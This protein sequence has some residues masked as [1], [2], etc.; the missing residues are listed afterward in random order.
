VDDLSK[1]TP[2]EFLLNVTG[3]VLLARALAI[4]TDLGVADIVADGPKSMAAL[5][6]ETGCDQDSLYRMLRM[7]AGHGVFAEDE[8][9]RFEL[10]PRAELLRADHPDSLREM[11]LLDWQDIQWNTYFGLPEAVRTGENA[12]ENAYGQRFFDYL[13]GHPEL[14]ALFDRRMSVVSQA[15]NA[16]VVKAYAFAEHDSIIDIGGGQGGLLAAIVDR[17]PGIVAALYE[18]PQVLADPVSLRAAGLLDNVARI[19]GNFFADVPAG[20]GLYVMKRIIHDWDDDRAAGILRG[21]RDAMSGTS[22]ILVIDAVIRPGNEPD[23]NKNLDLS[24]MALT[25]GRERT[26]EEF[27]DLFDASGLRLTRIIPTENPSTLSLIEGERA[28]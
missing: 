28:G 25:P 20:F 7:L 24:I 11:L 22:R 19:A 12:F 3:Q 1:P 8:L 9:R 10:T 21:C 5:A 2:K 18:Q 6:E 16:E 26:E 13:A 15:E 27:A 14:N 4:V 17:H 23:P